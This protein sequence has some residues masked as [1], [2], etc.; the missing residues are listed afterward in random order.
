[1]RRLTL[2]LALTVSFLATLQTVSASDKHPDDEILPHAN[3]VSVTNIK[4]TDD[5]LKYSDDIM[6]YT[7]QYMSLKTLFRFS[8]IN[9]S[10]HMK[11]QDARDAVNNLIKPYQECE[12]SFSE[13]PTLQNAGMILRKLREIQFT[14]SEKIPLED[15][16]RVTIMFFNNAM[17]S[18]NLKALFPSC[19][20]R[21][22]NALVNIIRP[23]AMFV[24]LSK[25]IHISIKEVHNINI[26]QKNWMLWAMMRAC[27]FM[28][29]QR[30][31]D[32]FKSFEQFD[33]Y[34]HPLLKLLAPTDILTTICIK[35]KDNAVK[36]ILAH[37][38]IERILYD[39]WRER[40]RYP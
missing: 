21:K 22:W 38:L 35:E 28:F 29:P 8:L 2:A 24:C 17:E 20:E 26:L 18:N 13:R 33:T 34:N 16:Q 11:I 36:E 19:M 40:V 9:K 30:V 37:E 6:D 23:S 31:D 4:R 27:D 7:I 3:V 25:N 5:V 14:F 32:Y 39:S 1:M 15:L 12:N 10:W